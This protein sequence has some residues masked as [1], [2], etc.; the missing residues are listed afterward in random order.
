M[1]ASSTTSR[2]RWPRCALLPGP[3][4]WSSWPRR[5]PRSTFAGARRVTLVLAGDHEVEAS[6]D[7]CACEI[8]VNLVFNRSAIPRPTAG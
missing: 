7:P 5:W 3:S 8:L 4:T 2:P 1:D 6:V